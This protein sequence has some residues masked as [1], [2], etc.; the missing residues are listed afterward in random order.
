LFPPL[1]KGRVREGIKKTDE[2]FVEIA[3]LRDNPHPE[4]VNDFR[5]PLFKGR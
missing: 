5:P 2:K 1:E 3:A 4:I